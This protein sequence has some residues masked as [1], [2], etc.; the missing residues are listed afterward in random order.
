MTT[1]IPA[2]CFNQGDFTLQQ[3]PP[4]LSQWV[5][6]LWAIQRRPHAEE[7]TQP[8]A[9]EKF[10]PDGG[11]SLTLDYSHG[12][13]QI[14]LALN[15]HTQAHPVGLWQDVVSVRFYPSGMFSVLGISAEVLTGA[16]MIFGS[17]FLPSKQSSLDALAEQIYPLSP[18]LR[19]AAVQQWL[20]QKAK[21]N[22][23]QIRC[24]S[25][26]VNAV[27]NCQL[28]VEQLAKSLGLT[29]RTL[30]RRFQKQVGVTPAEIMRL[31]RLKR[32]RALPGNL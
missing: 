9:V 30:E 8:P 1:I 15:R 17:E 14:S 27:Q 32:A 12:R 10:Y 24:A 2:Q 16:D 4:P 7:S 22:A 21:E 29:R 23:R 6:C 19:L 28:P 25:E 31:T 5:Q 20:G 13:P 18:A 3:P 26:L 11:V